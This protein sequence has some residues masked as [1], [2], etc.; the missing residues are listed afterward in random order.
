MTRHERIIRIITNGDAGDASTYER[1]IL[2]VA[3]DL[4]DLLP[5]GYDIDNACDALGDNDLD[6]TS[7]FRA[8][9]PLPYDVRGAVQRLIRGEN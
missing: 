5:P 8:R 9:Y 4:D 1:C 3:L 2:A 6:W 7:D